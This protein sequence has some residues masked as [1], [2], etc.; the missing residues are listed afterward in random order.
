MVSQ[1][2]K[3]IQKAQVEDMLEEATGKPTSLG[4]NSHEHILNYV[5]NLEPQQRDAFLR[6]IEQVVDGGSQ[7]MHPDPMEFMPTVSTVHQDKTGR[8]GLNKV[9]VPIHPKVTV[10]RKKEIHRRETLVPEFQQ[11]DFTPLEEV[12]QNRLNKVRTSNSQKGI[13]A[14]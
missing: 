8:K 6:A 12:S 10:D 4:E 14:V 7:A 9:G 13:P 1:S 3:D 11:S 2:L 5:Q